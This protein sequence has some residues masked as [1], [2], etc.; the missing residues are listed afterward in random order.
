MPDTPDFGEDRW[1]PDRMAAV[2]FIIRGER[3][4][5]HDYARLMEGFF[6]AIRGEVLKPILRIIDPFGVFHGVDRFN[7]MLTDFLTGGITKLLN[8]AYGRV[9]GDNF[10]F[11]N[12]PYVTRHLEEVRNKMVRTPEEVFDLIRTQVDNGINAGEGIP[13]LAERIDQTLLNAK[14]ERWVNRG[15]VVA[16]TESISAYN[17][18]TNDAFQVIQ[19]ETGETFEKVWLATMD[20]RTR[21]THFIADGQRVAFAQPFIVG[22]FPGF[23]PGDPELP[24][25]ER[26][27]CRCTF[28]VVEPG[29]SVDLAG[30]EWK[31]P[32][33]VAAE[34]AS[35]AAR[36]VQRA[37]D[38]SQVSSQER[39]VV[40]DLLAH[41]DELINNQ[42]SKR[43]LTARASGMRRAAGDYAPALEPL[44][45]AM[46]AGDATAMRSAIAE[47]EA[48]AGLATVGGQAGEFLRFD[49]ARMEPIGKARIQQG[50]PVVVLR[51]GYSTVIDGE[52]VVLMRAAVTSATEEE[53]AAGQRS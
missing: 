10:P 50:A 4:I 46:E 16:R 40:A 19:D 48:R 23:F 7:Q 18:G 35:R 45:L 11:S 3:D 8:T 5:Y 26:I 20:T 12:R 52:T 32:K 30:R 29:E 17:G 49:A 6:H 25:Q 9:L 33:R 38:A 1:L 28:L 53:Y 43:A 51:P 13:E 39:R 34:V 22:G 41:A 47:A 21:E 2:G 44:F 42:A 36:G 27:Q 31:N 37:G 14:A 24:A 15:V